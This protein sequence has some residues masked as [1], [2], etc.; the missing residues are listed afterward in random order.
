MSKNKKSQDKTS[1]RKF[2]MGAGAIATT[3]LLAACG[4]GDNSNASQGSATVI[5]AKRKLKMVT[6][7]PKSFPGMGVS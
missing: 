3:G 7:W 4:N 1:R 2:I 6:T 5:K